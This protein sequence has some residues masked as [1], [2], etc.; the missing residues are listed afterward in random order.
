M[1]ICSTKSFSQ[2]SLTGSLYGIVID[3]QSQRPLIGISVK[4]LDT[5]FG[6]STDADGKFTINNIPIGTYRVQFSG[7]GFKS[8]IRTDVIISTGHAAPINIE[9]DEQ[10]LLTEGIT[11]EAD[12]FQKPVEDV[13]SVHTF[14][15]EEIRRA[16]GAAED[17]SRLVQSMPGVSAST[18]A[19]NDLIVRGGSPTE[20]L[21]LLDNIEV[22]NANHFGTQGATG[23]PIGMINVDFIDEVNFYAGGFS[24][25]YGDKLSSVLDIKLREGN[26]QAFQGD[27]NLSSGGFGGVFEGPIGND[28]TWMFSARKSYLDLLVG[29]IGLG[30]VPNYSDLQTKVQWRFDHSNTLSFLGLAGIDDIVMKSGDENKQ[31]PRTL[32]TNSRDFQHQYTFGLKWKSLWS[33]KGFSEVVISHSATNYVVDVK[34]TVATL[35][36]KNTSY[37]A[38]TQ[39]K[40]EAFY[41]LTSRWGILGG[42]S[43]KPIKYEHT[44]YVHADSTALGN[45]L[46]ILDYHRNESTSKEAAYFQTTY[47]LTTKLT[48]TLG[49]RYDHFA[50]TNASNLS[51]R[52]G[53][54]FSI[55]PVTHF[56]LSYGQ[57]YQTPAY[58]WVSG[59]PSNMSLKNIRADHYIVG[60][61]HYP[62]SDTKISVEAYDKEYS[63]YPV[64]V[65]IPTF[66]FINGGAAY[67]SFITGPAVNAGKGY[68]RGVDVFLQKKMSNNFYGLISYS[69]SKSEFKALE[70]GWRPGDFDYRHV[71]TISGGVKLSD[72]WEISAKWRYADGRPYTPFNEAASKLGHHGVADVQNLNALR[73]PPYHR[74]DVRVD[75]RLHFTGWSIVSYIDL[76]NLYNRINVYSYYWDEVENKQAQV[77]Q[78]AF[79]PIGGFSIE[80]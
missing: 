58:L 32:F 36:F 57:F 59:D 76:Q 79:F 3:H 4:I 47:Q 38:E 37:E 25:K 1:I 44:V 39:L 73:S 23:G 20:N 35:I 24:A 67:G 30:A 71:F 55:S 80:F 8:V 5:K 56:N 6:A 33:D 75:Y 60:V 78:W 34:D 41:Q 46:P 74:L 17:V 66:I 27:I 13:N 2:S 77:N 29:P 40:A 45:P 52:A 70:G 69:Y 50:I 62:W 65:Y 48:F 61:E 19:R 54:T 43:F 16:A 21:T 28:A 42:I 31:E 9:M 11:I 49:G 18:D 64:S 53:V 12:Y 7:V 22:P 14:N 26:S 15:F 68:V 10:V 63:N 51:P 72:E